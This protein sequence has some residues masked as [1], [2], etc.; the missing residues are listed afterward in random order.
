MKVGISIDTGA[1]E[2]NR[3]IDSSDN[4]VVKKGDVNIDEKLTK[5]TLKQKL[6]LEKLKQDMKK[7]RNKQDGIFKVTMRKTANLYFYE[8]ILYI[9]VTVLGVQSKLTVKY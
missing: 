9:H 6:K 7:K 3:K 2:W 4:S 8:N 1:I 5:V